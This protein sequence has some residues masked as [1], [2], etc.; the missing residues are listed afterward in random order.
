MG[1]PFLLPEPGKYTARLIEDT[2]GNYK[3][4]TG[5]YEKKLQPEMV[6]YYPNWFELKLFGSWKDW[7][8]LS[9]PL[10]KQN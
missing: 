1:R 8:V 9:K 7:N 10:D 4:D 5:N 3:W 2:N 6:Y